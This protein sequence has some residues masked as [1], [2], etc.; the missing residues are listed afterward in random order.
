MG[1]WKWLLRIGSLLILLGFFMPAVL[2]SCNVGFNE[3]IQSFSLAEVA[4]YV[5][6]PILYVVPALSIVAIILSFLQGESGSRDVALLWGQLGAIVL[7][8]L[9]LA[10]T[11]F[12]MASEVRRGTY[13][14]IKITPTYGTYLIIGSTV[15][16]LISWI[17]QK[18]LLTQPVKAAAV[19]KGDMEKQQE[20]YLENVVFSPPIPQH[21]PANVSHQLPSTYPYLLLRSGNYPSRQIQ[22]SSDYFSIGRASTSQ[23]H[24]DDTTVSRNHA[25][26]RYSQGMWFLQDQESSGG[27]FVNGVR[28]DAIRLN[29]GDEIGIGPYRFQFRLDG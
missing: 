11:I 15:L 10:G 25:V 1:N 13:N 17:Y 22:I 2:V 26:F 16:C 4:D 8:L 23:I 5:D 21:E 27:T 19:Y 7:Q 12:S 9:V 24:L 20:N 14:T 3:P 6:V 18:K 28:T 29:N